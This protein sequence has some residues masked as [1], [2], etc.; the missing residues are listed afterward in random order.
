MLVELTLAEYRWCSRIALVRCQRRQLVQRRH[1]N[2]RCLVFKAIFEYV[3]RRAHV[4]GS[5][6]GRRQIN[7]GA[8]FRA[9]RVLRL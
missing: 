8:A 4:R 7:I 1:H 2:R 9:T 3:A 5:A 6:K